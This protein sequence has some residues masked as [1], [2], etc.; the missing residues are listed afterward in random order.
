VSA[1]GGGRRPGLPL[2]VWAGLLSSGSVAAACLVTALVL[3]LTGRLSA[4][5]LEALAAGVCAGLVLALV[6]VAAASR[7]AA[8]L[9]GLNADAARRLRDP[10]A[11]IARPGRRPV[12][13]R[14]AHELAE[15]SRTLEA[16]H[17]RV[18]VADEVGQ[19]H[20]RDAETAGAGVFELLSGLVAAE[21]G[22]RGQLAAELHDTVAQSLMIARGMLAAGPSTP[23]EIAR[24]TDYVE[25]AEEQVR[26]VMAR[27]RPPALRD[28]NLASAVSQLQADFRAR[29]AIEVRV[30]WPAEPHPLP[31][32]SAVTVYRF[33]QEA[34]LNVVKH[35]DVE[36]AVVTLSVS[37]EAVVA[38]VRDEGPGFDPRA[39]RSDRGRHVGLGLLRERARLAG[40][41][42]EVLSA[43]GAGTTLAL[44][45]RLPRAVVPSQRPEPAAEHRPTAP[46]GPSLT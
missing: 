40:G 21:E 29:Y 1:P 15:L 16:L 17:L 39:V 8:S 2:A 26:A 27:T 4:A 32:S 10:A 28:G 3:G 14:A 25:D 33:F 37:S 7:L 42:L 19:R 18:R 35:A 30:R 23:T 22:A 6:A 31:L 46:L 41:R 20:R 45:L 38:T 11:P 5:A 43:P 44:T 36:E 9:R 12:A 34:L 24:L 13:A